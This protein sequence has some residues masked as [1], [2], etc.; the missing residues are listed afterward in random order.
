[1]RATSRLERERR[2]P[3]QEGSGR[4]QA[5]AGP[6]APGR[7]LK[8]GRDILVW[9]GSGLRAVPGTPVGISL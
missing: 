2:R 3:V 7:E 4:G 5:A 8:F 6:G 1:V 9:P